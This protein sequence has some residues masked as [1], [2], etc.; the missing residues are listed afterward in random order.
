MNIQENID[1]QVAEYPSPTPT[2]DV[3]YQ[4]AVSIYSGSVEDTLLAHRPCPDMEGVANYDPQNAVRGQAHI[5]SLR[6]KFGLRAQRQKKQGNPLG[7]VC[8]EHECTGP[9]VGEA[10]G[11]PKEVIDDRWRAKIKEKSLRL[12]ERA[13]LQPTRSHNEAAQH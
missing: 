6:A 10:T 7:Y 3:S 1:K 13:I 8:T 5:E 4:P 11:K 12:P 9:L 2:D